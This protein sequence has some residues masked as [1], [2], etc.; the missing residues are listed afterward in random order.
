MSEVRVRMRRGVRG[1]VTLDFT[2][3]EST[4]LLIKNAAIVVNHHEDEAVSRGGGQ[5]RIDRGRVRG[6]TDSEVLARL[7]FPLRVAYFFRPKCPTKN[8]LL[9]TVDCR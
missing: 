1:V 9:S 2:I 3:F 7:T 5:K 4:S 8:K 6:K